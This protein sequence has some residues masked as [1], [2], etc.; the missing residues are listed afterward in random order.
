M[1]PATRLLILRISIPVMTV[2]FILQTITGLGFIYNF[3]NSMFGD[4]HKYAGLLFTALVIF[5][6]ILNWN[7]I[8]ANYSKHKPKSET[9]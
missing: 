8:I 4:I 7:W 6:I 3:G 5:H 1:K 9:K 2:L